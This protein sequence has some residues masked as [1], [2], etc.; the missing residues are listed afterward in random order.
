[1]YLR[2]GR[3]PRCDAANSISVLTLYSR[4]NPDMAERHFS[5][6]EILE[7]A[8]GIEHRASTFYAEAAGNASDQQ[9]AERLNA[10]AAMEQDHERTF[11]RMRDA[12]PPES[13][14]GFLDRGDEM[15]ALIQVGR[16]YYGWEG[17]AGPGK[18]LT[19]R[20]SRPDLLRYALDAEEHTV[21]FY[22]RLKTFCDVPEDRE[23]IERIVREEQQH[24]AAIRGLI[25]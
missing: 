20:E 5:P 9:T 24:V 8:I 19:G 15:L 11:T 7:T 25:G 6:A 16:T 17:K 14:E 1:M 13:D 10:L 12:L 18:S 21:E 4:G 2:P 22:S 23:H 3:A